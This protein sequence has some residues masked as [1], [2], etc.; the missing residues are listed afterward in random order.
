MSQT[1]TLVVNETLPNASK[2]DT[3]MCQLCLLRFLLA[4]FQHAQLGLKMQALAPT[5]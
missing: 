4:D 3:A 5:N 1:P 2:A